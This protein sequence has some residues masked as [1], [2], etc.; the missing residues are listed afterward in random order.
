MP[1]RCFYS[2]W[3]LLGAIHTGSESYERNNEYFFPIQSITNLFACVTKRLE[4]NLTIMLMVVVV[5]V[6]VVVLMLVYGE[7]VEH[8]GAGNIIVNP[9]IISI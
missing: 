3:S 1:E 5:V 2:H 7:L 4:L 6:V 9:E 8:H